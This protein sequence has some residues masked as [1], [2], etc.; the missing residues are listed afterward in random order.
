MFEKY[1]SLG[2]C[3]PRSSFPPSPFINNKLRIL[4][5]NYEA[6]SVALVGFSSHNFPP[7][8]LLQLSV[9]VLAMS[10]YWISDF[11]LGYKIRPSQ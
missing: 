10:N 3:F 8:T 11:W 5:V 2:N 1:L 9:L 6:T 7:F 4:L